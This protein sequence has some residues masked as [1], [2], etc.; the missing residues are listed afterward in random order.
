MEVSE[1]W[2][3]RHREKKKWQMGTT[4]RYISREV[5]IWYGENKNFAITYYC[6]EIAVIYLVWILKCREVKT[7]T[8]DFLL[9][10]GFS[11]L[12]GMPFLSIRA[13]YN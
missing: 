9:S 13:E 10:I 11:N 8:A 12:L 2:I 6:I 1:H 5:Y 3:K 4:N 7:V